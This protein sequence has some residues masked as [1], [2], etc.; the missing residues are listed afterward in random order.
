MF[1]RRREEEHVHAF[2]ELPVVVV[3]DVLHDLL[4]E[5]VGEAAR[6]EAVLQAAVAV[7]VD[8]VGHARLRG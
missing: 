2:H 6:I 7:V 3:D 1:V 5:P 8:V 4:I